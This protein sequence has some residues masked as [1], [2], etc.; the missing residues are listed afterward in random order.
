MQHDHAHSFSVA[1]VNEQLERTLAGAPFTASKRLGDVLRL[2][3]EH[4][5]SD[6]SYVLKERTIAIKA[7][8]RPTTFDSRLDS[9]VRVQ[10]RR[11]RAALDRYYLTDGV[12][13]P[14]RID[15]TVGAY[16][17]VFRPNAAD[18]GVLRTGF[19][20]PVSL[21]S[22]IGRNDILKAL[23]EALDGPHRLI[24]LTGPGGSGKSRVA[25]EDSPTSETARSGRWSNWPP[26]AIRATYRW[27]S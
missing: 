25:L 10:V 1:E 8:G 11:L 17:A 16:Q 3:V 5:L 4:T 15:I 12:H 21:T 23:A 18:H 14:V 27:R 6:T 24:T 9:S 7:M 20:G 2:I 19:S 22:F 13:D 26:S